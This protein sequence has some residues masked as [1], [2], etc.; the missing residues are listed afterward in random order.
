[1]GIVK[2]CVYFVL[3]KRYINEPY[4]AHQSAELTV[5]AGA[6]K[7]ATDKDSCIPRRLDSPIKIFQSKF[8]WW[9]FRICRLKFKEMSRDLLDCTV[10]AGFIRVEMLFF[11]NL[12]FVSSL[13]KNLSPKLLT[14]ILKVSPLNSCPSYLAL[15]PILTLSSSNKSNQSFIWPQTAKTNPKSHFSAHL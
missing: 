5:S 15:N 11:K 4:L 7:K 10:W 1:M 13:F 8:W 3:E 12:L 2:H 14:V 6:I 9:E